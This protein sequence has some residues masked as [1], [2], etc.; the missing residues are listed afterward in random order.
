ML[1][2]PSLAS[3]TRSSSSPLPPHVLRFSGWPDLASL[4]ACRI[5]SRSGPEHASRL[6]RVGWGL[7]LCHQGLEVGRRPAEF[8]RRSVEL[9]REGTKPISHIAKD[10]GISESCCGT[11]ATEADIDEAARKA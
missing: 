11:G 9:A 6:H 1:M 4:T 8:R 10:L 5:S 7:R 2:W 3:G